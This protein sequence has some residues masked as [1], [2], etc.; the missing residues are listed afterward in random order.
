MNPAN[1][2]A[3]FGGRRCCDVVLATTDASRTHIT[4]I[5]RNLVDDSA[6]KMIRTGRPST[7]PSIMRRPHCDHFQVCRVIPR[8]MIAVISCQRRSNLSDII[9]RACFTNRTDIGRSP[10]TWSERRSTR[11]AVASRRI[12]RGLK[13]TSARSEQLV[14]LRRPLQKQAM[15]TEWPEQAFG[16]L[17]PSTLQESGLSHPLFMGSPFCV[18]TKKAKSFR[19][20]PLLLQD[21]DRTTLRLLPRAMPQSSADVGKRLE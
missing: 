20:S 18:D 6:L 5:M 2:R 10:C 19:S 8:S 11:S 7:T 9:S 13:T 21:D 15:I 12:L 4:V 17:A 16:L 1:H 14:V 3:C